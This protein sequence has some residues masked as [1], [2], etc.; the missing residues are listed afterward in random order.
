MRVILVSLIMA[1]ILVG[2]MGCAKKSTR[3][4]EVR[5]GGKKF[6]VAADIRTPIVPGNSDHKKKNTKGADADEADVSTEVKVAAKGLSINWQEGSQ[7]KL[8]ATAS[9]GAI[10]SLSG[11]A[12]M[13]VVNAELYDKGKLVA[14]LTAPVVQADKKS[15]L[16][17]ATGGVTIVSCVSGSN[18]QKVKADRVKWLSKE[19]RMIGEGNVLA[20]GPTASIKASAFTADTRLRTVKV[21]ADPAQAHA[22]FGKK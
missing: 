16:V 5:T 20:I 4:I 21:Y 9:K 13:M 8:K 7:P 1:S 11:A 2:T 19:N 15:D 17:I 10:N 18:I 14:K 6:S 22:E 3:T 12:S